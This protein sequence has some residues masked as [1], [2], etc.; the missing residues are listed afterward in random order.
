MLTKK[1]YWSLVCYNSPAITAYHIADDYYINEEGILVS[2]L[3]ASNQGG[4]GPVH[5][6]LK[7]PNEADATLVG[8]DFLGRKGAFGVQSSCRK[9]ASRYFK[10]NAELVERIKNKEFKAEEIVELAKAYSKYH[11]TPQSENEE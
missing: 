3:H 6:L 9:L 5:L 10:E 4:A 7:R 1:E 8:L 11:E 2:V